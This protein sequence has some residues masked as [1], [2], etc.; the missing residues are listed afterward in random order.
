MTGE[1]VA[2][3]V[4][5]TRC[6]LFVIGLFLITLTIDAA[7]RRRA[8]AAPGVGADEITPHGWLVANAHVL[9]TV[10][11]TP[12]TS[13]LFPL[14]AMIGSSEVVGIGDITHGTHEV[15]TVKLR[16]IDYL[17]REMGFDVVGWEAPFPL[18]ERVNAYIQGEGGDLRSLLG[19]MHRLTYFFWDAEE[20]FDVIEWMREY[21]AHRGER[22]PVQ[23]V[24]FDVT[25]P[26]AASNAVVAYLRTVDPAAAVTAEEQYA[27]ARASSLSIDEACKTKAT[28]ILNSI[29]T[30]EAELT[31]LSSASAF[32]EAL[33]QARVVVQSRWIFGLERDQAMAEN[34]LSLRQRRGVARRMIL[35]AH[36][37]HISEAPIPLL[38]DRPMG[39][40]LAETLAGDYFSITTMT[41]A[42]SYLVWADPTRTQQYQP[43]TKILPTLLP[44][45][46]EASIRQ[47]G[48][49]YLL[50]PFRKVLP[51]WLTT[52]TQFHMAPAAGSISSTVGVLPA[53]YDAAIFMDTTTAMHPLAH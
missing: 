23:V 39:R 33:H 35:W 10:A 31:A 13:D 5:M 12:D 27:C 43:V 20:I 34:V 7:P 19:E 14:R 52:S 50:I 51:G 25:Q 28:S 6:A 46:Y 36:S 3:H 41:A 16:V 21:N 15:Y 30:R 37:A 18:V 42:G 26:D 32:A 9:N 53:S 2:V 11:L 38:G 48:E 22:P 24:G 44:T 17:V 47:R 49:P 29:A 4:S 40:V 45:A 1:S 8:V